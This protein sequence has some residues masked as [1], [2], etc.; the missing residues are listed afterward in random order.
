MAHTGRC[1]DCM[2]VVPSD[3]HGDQGADGESTQQSPSLTNE[4]FRDTRTVL[5]PLMVISQA[6]R[7]GWRFG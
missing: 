6:Y 1:P 5:V 4:G 2:R 7:L 3:S